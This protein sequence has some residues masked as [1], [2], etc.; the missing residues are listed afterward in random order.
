ML[1]LYLFSRTPIDLQ[2]VPF[3]HERFSLFVPSLNVGQIGDVA[4]IVSKDV[5]QN[6][7]QF[8]VGIP[9]FISHW[10]W[11]NDLPFYFTMQGSCFF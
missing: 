4:S 2:L 1:V 7:F 11:V 5:F 8:N 10:S 3:A 6:P 9:S